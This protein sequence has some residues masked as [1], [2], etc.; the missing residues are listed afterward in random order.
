[1]AGKIRAYIRVSTDQQ[2]LE[3]DKRDIIVFAH[4]RDLGK[5]EFVEEKV[6][7]RK[8]W[9]SRS[10]GDMVETSG[11]GDVIIVPEL[12]R[13][14]RSMLEIMEILSVALNKGIRIYAIS[15]KWQ[16]DD[17]IQSKV[18][19]MAFSMAA[20]IQVDLIRYQTRKALAQRKADGMKLGRPKGSG[21][22]KLDSHREEIEALLANGSTQKHIAEKYHTSPVNLNRWLKRQGIR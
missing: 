4:E 12:T 22:S 14:G 15:G 5:V 21:K 3:K 11:K 20:E 6:S 7:G 9:K 17:S 1:M 13:L 2:D 19:A 10:I 16:L 8:H 18:V